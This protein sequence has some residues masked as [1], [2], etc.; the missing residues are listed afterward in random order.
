RSIPDR[1]SIARATRAARNF[2]RSTGLICALG[3]F[4]FLGG[5]AWAT[6]H[7][8]FSILFENDWFYDAD[9]DYTNGVEFAYTT[10]PDETPEALKDFTHD[11]PLMSDTGDVRASY[12][13]GQDIFTPA[14][15]QLANPPTTQ[16]PYAG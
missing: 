13:L 12:E 4:A 5:P 1:K 11:L 14:A 6:E 8:S 16:R 3:F 10:A 2:M 7:S 9:R 15:T